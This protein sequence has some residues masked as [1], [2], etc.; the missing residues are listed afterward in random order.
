MII[1]YG[2]DNCPYCDA[3]IRFL[4]AQKLPYTYFEA[5]ND[6]VKRNEMLALGKSKT[7]P[8]IIINGTAI[9]GYDDLKQLHQVGKLETLL[10]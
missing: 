4:D 10:K 2:K 1:I 9:G 3:A 5:K 6:E 7:Y 8:Q